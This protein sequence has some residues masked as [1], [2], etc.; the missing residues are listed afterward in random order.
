MRFKELA[1][2]IRLW[3][4]C[5]LIAISLTACSLDEAKVLGESCD[6]AYI[7]L[8]SG[9]QIKP[10]ND[11]YDVYFE[12]HLC[13]QEVPY[14][15][16]LVDDDAHDEIRFCSTLKETCPEGMHSYNGMCEWDSAAHCGSHFEDCLNAEKHPGWKEAICSKSQTCEVA[17]CD[18][19]YHV[20]GNGCEE[21]S[22]LNCGTH[23]TKC[24]VDNAT[25][26][27][28]N[29]SCTFECGDGFHA[30]DGKCVKSECKGTEV[31]CFNENNIGKKQVCND[32]VLEEAV[33]CPNNNSCNAEQTDCGVCVNGE[34]KC[35]NDGNLGKK[36]ICNDGVLGEAVHCPDNNSCNAEQTDCGVC[37]NG[38]AFTDVSGQK[39]CEDGKW[40]PSKC[41][42]GKHEFDGSCEPD[43]SHNCGAHGVTCADEWTCCLVTDEVLG[44]DPTGEL[45]NLCQ[46]DTICCVGDSVNS[47]VEAGA[48]PACF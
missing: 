42:F 3:H 2:N 26:Y 12:R 24:D 5:T 31:K 20:Y 16:T 1:M 22:L 34:V 47:G 33:N 11:D 45:E 38:T 40:V 46:P 18:S 13:P 39:F 9:E 32:G 23:G 10:G 44:S 35:M 43:S 17:G 41:E 25:N 8:K 15:R 36:Q 6:A 21:D 7:E 4:I 48:S 19:D 30:V 37:V 28:K 29:G 14:C 27:C